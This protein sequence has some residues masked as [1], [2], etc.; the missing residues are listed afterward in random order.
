MNKPQVPQVLPRSFYKRSSVEV[1]RELLGARLIR[2]EEGDRLA[3][4]ILETEAYQGEEDLACHARAGKTPRTQVMYGPGGF[5]YVYFTY[6]AHWM[7]NAVAEP[8]GIPAAVLVRAIL[9]IEGLEKMA[10]FRP[11]PTRRSLPDRPAPAAPFTGW[12]D[13]PAK[14]CQALNV[15]GR[16][17][18]ADLCDPSGELFIEAGEPIPEGQVSRG[19]R[20]GINNVP[21]PWKSKPWRFLVNKI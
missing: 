4:M 7:L 21:E 17:N 8:E 3:G 15:T 6:G 13:G 20:I 16:L 2:R 19:P 18:G 14:L 10:E 12:T 9:P 11:L 5:A 1:A